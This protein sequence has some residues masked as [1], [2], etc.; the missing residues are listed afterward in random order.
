MVIRN[1]NFEDMEQLGHIHVHIFRTAFSEFITFP[2]SRGTGLGHAML[3][4]ALNRIGG[5]KEF[6]WASKENKRASRFYEKIG[7]HWEGTEQVSELTGLGYT[8][9]REFGGIADWPYEV[10]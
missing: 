10:E 6:L 9:V 5:R 4:E 3:T 1:A 2:E 8:N 7:F